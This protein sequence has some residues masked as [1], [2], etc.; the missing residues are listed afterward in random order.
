[1]YTNNPEKG[2]LMALAC[3]YFG[4]EGLEVGAPLHFYLTPPTVMQILLHLFSLCNFLSAGTPFLLTPE[5]L[6]DPFWPSP[7]SF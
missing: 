7:E 3:T 4:G 6:S 1:V 2:V 5:E